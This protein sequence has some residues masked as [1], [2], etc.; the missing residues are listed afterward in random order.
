MEMWLLPTLLFLRHSGIFFFFFFY[1]LLLLYFSPGEEGGESSVS[2]FGTFIS[3]THDNPR[4]NF[5]EAEG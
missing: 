4:L 1:T 5:F 3:Q 2:V